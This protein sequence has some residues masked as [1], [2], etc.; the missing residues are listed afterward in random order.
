MT[1]KKTLFLVKIKMRYSSVD[2]KDVST[3][4]RSKVFSRISS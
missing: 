4:T 1:K 3:Y 2:D